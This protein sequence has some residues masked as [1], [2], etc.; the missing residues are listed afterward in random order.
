MDE[1]KD[2]LVAHRGYRAHFPE[3][4]ATGILA[5][6]EEGAKHIEFDV[7]MNADHDLVL[8]HD[9][10][11][12][13]TAERDDSIFETSSALLKSISVHE[14]VRFGD[15][16]NP[17]PVPLLSDILEICLPFKEVQLFIEV[18]EESIQHWGINTVMSRLIKQL[19]HYPNPCCVI[20]FDEKAIAYTQQHSDIPCGWV[21]HQYDQD[22]LKYAKVLSPDFL[23]CNENK[24]PRDKP[25]HRGDWQWMLYG[26]LNAEQLE[27]LSQLGCDLFETDFI[28]EIINELSNKKTTLT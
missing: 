18:K 24:V 17:E 13:H 1:F 27:P 11:F 21:L 7:Q 6:I 15:R 8:L 20:S 28:G 3:N 12:L 26:I 5:A 10:N 4:S 2:K 19:L 25:L 22:T 14:F 23:I 9:D 16:Y